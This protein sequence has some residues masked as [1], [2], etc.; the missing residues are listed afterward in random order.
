[1]EQLCRTATAT[2][3]SKKTELTTA[4]ES[5]L[6]IMHT[7]GTCPKDFDIH[8]GRRQ[9]E[10]TFAPSRN[11]PASHSE[12]NSLASRMVVFASASHGR[13]VLH[14]V[15][16]LNQLSSRAAPHCV[17]HIL[18]LQSARTVICVCPFFGLN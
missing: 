1:M 2:D 18:C 16:K 8:V 12:A 17:E 10:G 4:L 11:L 7:G 5:W 6:I 15:K 14:S 9:L 13:N 3:G